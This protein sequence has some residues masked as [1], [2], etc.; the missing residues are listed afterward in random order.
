MLSQ[1]LT[2]STKAI[3]SRYCAD[4]VR[5]LSGSCPDLV[6]GE[7]RINTKLYGGQNWTYIQRL[8]IS[9]QVMG[10]V[11]RALSIE[12]GPRA[13]FATQITFFNKKSVNYIE[14]MTIS[15]KVDFSAREARR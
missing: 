2:R 12:G 9:R 8:T 4:L 15:K 14:Q 13:W 7:D 1:T 10:T 6:R 3:L 5:K 11:F